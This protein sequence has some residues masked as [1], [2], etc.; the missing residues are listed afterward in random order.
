[1]EE[2]VDIL[3]ENGRP[4]QSTLLKK[5]A[6]RLGHFHATVHVW[7]YSKSGKILLQQRG[8]DKKTFPLLW[9]VS[10]AGH[11]SAGE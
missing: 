11:V 4:T 10:V 2:Y 3:D 7:C 8:K 9:D 1:M 5:E 6:H